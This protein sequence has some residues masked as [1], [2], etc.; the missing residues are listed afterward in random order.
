MAHHFKAIHARHFDVQQHHRRHFIFQHFQRFDTVMRGGDTVAFALQEARGDLAYGQ[1]V[2]H[3]HDQRRQF[4][5]FW[6]T[7][8]LH[9]GRAFS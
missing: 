6:F 4:D 8:N 7:F 9:H 2:I 5:V 1:R 3:H